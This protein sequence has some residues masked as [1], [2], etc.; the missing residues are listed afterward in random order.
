MSSVAF[1]DTFAQAMMPSARLVSSKGASCQHSAVSFQQKD[2]SE[3]DGFWLMAVVPTL[4]AAGSRSPRLGEFRKIG[5]V[6][7]LAAF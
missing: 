4:T 2:A 6:F 7:L 1:L 3:P 5:R